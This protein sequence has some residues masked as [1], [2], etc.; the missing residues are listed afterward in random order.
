[1]AISYVNGSS[2][3]LVTI[4]STTLTLTLPSGIQ[5]D[6]LILIYAANGEDSPQPS[7]TTAPSGYTQRGSGVFLDYG[8]GGITG[9]LWWKIAGASESSPT[10]TW[11]TGASTG[12]G[13]WA[14]IVV[15][16]GVD[17]TDPF[18][19]ASVSEG[20]N[21]AAST[22]TPPSVTTQTNN[23]WVVSFIQTGDNNSN[24]LLSGSEQG[25]T[26]R[27]VGN[28]FQT[29]TGSDAGFGVADKEITSAGS[30]TMPTWQQTTLASDSWGYQTIALKPATVAAFACS[31]SRYRFYDVGNPTTNS[32]LAAEN[33]AVAPTVGTFF[34]TQLRVQL[35]ETGGVSGVGTDDYKLQYQI[36]SGGWT[37]VGNT[38][39]ASAVSMYD[40]SDTFTH[41]GSVS[42]ARLTAGTGSFVNGELADTSNTVTDHQ[43]T[44][45]N[46]T[47]HVWS[48]V[49]DP[50]FMSSSSSQTIEFRVLRNNV[51]TD[52][53]YTV[54][55][56]INLTKS[57]GYLQSTYRFYE[58]GTES[59]STAIAAA[60]TDITRDLTSD[61][62]LQLRI[63]VIDDNNFANP[64]TDDWQLQYNKNNAGWTNVGTGAVVGYNSASLTEGGATTDRLSISGFEAGKISEDGE[65]N[66]DSISAGAATEY[67]FSI[68][69]VA[70][71]VADGD[72]IDFRIIRNGSSSGISYG[73]LPT[74]T[75]D[76]PAS[77]SFLFEEHFDNTDGTTITSGNSGFNIYNG[78]GTKT[79]QD[80]PTP[81]GGSTVAEFG[82]T[83]GNA[84][85]I[86][87]STILP[88]ATNGGTALGLIYV[89]FY[90]RA[91]ASPS[92]ITRLCIFEESVAAGGTD[93]GGIRLNATGL[94][95]IMDGGTSRGAST[96]AIST[97][98]WTRVEAELDQGNTITARMW[99]GADV[100]SASTG[101]TNYETWSGAL[102]NN[103]DPMEVFGIG[104][105]ATGGDLNLYIDEFVVDDAGWIGPYSPGAA[106]A[107]GY[108]GIPMD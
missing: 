73:N 54:T 37:D 35:Q 83:G 25:F 55:P 81:I 95:A 102:T 32:A 53:T 28:T 97:T 90:V 38:S 20:T 31:Q 105:Y 29:T 101:A 13:L 57:P 12:G 48:M 107:I 62:N 89:R 59:A 26:G 27:L 18:D 49:V 36:N 46:Y 99:W 56:T 100:N 84:S 77:G 45:S 66:D 86:K 103:P 64:S 67:L 65:V 87:N 79:Y 60:N 78:G 88:G 7:V 10:I 75:V 92:A 68:T 39:G 34:Y 41:G 22:F 47:E 5:Q 76:I 16:R 23:A 1:M 50:E 11:N 52:M 108:F 33:T 2:A 96:H 85:W 82:A 43:L 15:Y 69:V 106:P 44:A 74:I 14:V 93:V 94:F 98:E 70:A 24:D 17:T 3:V 58:D 42:S 72:V 63:G 51:S 30:V 9:T 40:E 61:S 104:S 91:S 19:L 4:A 21:S 80:A 71:S 6:D 8:S